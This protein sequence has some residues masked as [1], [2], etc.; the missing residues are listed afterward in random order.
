M[1]KRETLPEVD[2]RCLPVG[3]RVGP[4]RVVGFGGL[5]SYGTLYRVELVGH[6]E[7]GPSA[8]KLAVYPGDPRFERE[9]WLL[10]R[11]HSP[12]VPRLQDQGVWEHASGSYP[13]LV[14]DWVDGEPLYEWASRR[15]PSQRQVLGLV[16]QVARALVATHAAGG[17][18]RDVKGANVLVRRADGQA[19]LTDFGAGDYRGAETLTSKLLPPGT[20]GYRSP[21][22]WA[23]LNAFRRHP[24]VHYPASTCDDLF[25][26]GVMAY[27]LV[28]DHYP[29]LTNPEEPGSEVWREG[30]SGPRPPSALN[31]QVGPELD[32]LILRL[33][34]VAPEERFRG[35]AQ[36]VAEAA[37]QAREKIRPDTDTL[38]FRWSHAYSPGWRSPEAVRRSAE[39]DAAAREKLARRGAEGQARAASAPERARRSGFAR[40][41]S[42]GGAAAAVALLLVLL[43]GGVLHRAHEV[44]WSAVAEAVSVAVGDG[45]ILS[46]SER[47]ATKDQDA[48][49]H[50]VGQPL[51]DKP[52]PD[53]RKPPCS[54]NGQVEIRGGCWYRIDAKPP[55]EEQAYAW[56]GACYM[57]VPASRRQQPTADPP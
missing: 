17:L 34:A 10:S 56:Q 18:H 31:P 52:L 5:G 21:E 6:E 30:G 51:P 23:F 1:G 32:A 42:V 27:R 39:R 55:C 36:A 44:L 47:P 33:L 14:M 20:P 2:P 46:P 24:T 12:Y 11:T 49:A 48:H 22:A 50:A 19:F 13:Y 3:T 25:A 40:A 29:P 57:P 8:L 28:T 15:N 35:V 41:W 26:L 53:Q 37:E 9:A 43:M 7:A 45:P 4:W 16:E 54:K 38:L